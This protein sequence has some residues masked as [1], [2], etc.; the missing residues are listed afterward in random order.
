MKWFDKL[1]HFIHQKL[2]NPPRIKVGDIV[3][4]NGIESRVMEICTVDDR[5]V[6]SELH[7]WER[8]P[9]Y[10]LKLVKSIKSS[11]FKPGDMV[12]INDITNGE[13]DTYIFNWV[14]IMD[15]IIE[16]GESVEVIHSESRPGD[17]QIV[18]VNWDGLWVPFMTYHI[19]LVVD[20]DIV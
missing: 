4:Y 5:V 9:L 7:P 12:T 1:L 18:I 17:G 19:E 8:I 14:T 15:K 10:K 6:L 20:Y 11:N 2:T 3:R 13:M 16:S